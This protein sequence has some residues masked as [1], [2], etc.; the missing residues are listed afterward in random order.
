MTWTLRGDRLRQSYRP[1]ESSRR[2]FSTDWRERPVVDIAAAG[3]VVD[4]DGLALAYSGTSVR[5]ATV[6]GSGLEVESSTSGTAY[7]TYRLGDLLPGWARSTIRLWI[8]GDLALS[9]NTRFLRGG[10]WNS[11]F[12]VFAYSELAH[13]TAP[14]ARTRDHVGLYDPALAIAAGTNVLAVEIYGTGLIRGR[15]GE[16]SG[17]GTPPE[18]ADLTAFPDYRAGL[19]SP[20]NL[21]ASS[22]SATPFDA[23]S[24]VGW[25]MGPG[26]VADTV[27]IRRTRLEVLSPLR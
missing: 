10:I 15:H 5:C 21:G 26:G 9:G 2:S 1:R 17:T 14:R 19:S 20:G 23:D 8:Y 25:A 18:W 24:R 27:V 16:W 11:A 4:A 22:N 6:G 3:S 7:L 12:T 13:S